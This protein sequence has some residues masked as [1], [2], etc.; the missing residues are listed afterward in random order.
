MSAQPG[1]SVVTLIKGRYEV[2]STLGSGGEAQ[3]VKALDRQHDRFVAL[4]I[5][6]VGDEATREELLS[7]ARV[8]FALPPHP[9][10]PIVR[11]DFFDGDTYVVAMDWVDGTSLAT[12][13]ADR[14]HPGLAPSSVLAYLAQAAE[15]LT[16]L[17][18]QSPPV[19]HGDVKPGNL[20]LARGGRIKLVDFGLSSAPNGSLP[21]AGTPG[22]RAP[23]LAAGGSL[24][25][26]SDVYA[27]ASTAFALLTGAAPTGVLPVWQH[28]SRAQAEQLEAAIRLGLATDPARRPKT[29]GELVERLQV[30]WTSGLPTG[31]VTF[32]VSD[33]EG[34]TAL[35]DARPE[36]MPDALVRHNELIAEAVEACGG[37]VIDSMGGGDST[38]SV[39]DS[40]PA[41]VQAALD[42]NRALQAEDWP[43][44]LRITARWGVHTG[45]AE[46][47]QLHYAGPTI[48]RAA[49][50]RAEAD[51]GQIFLSSATAELA[52]AHLPEGC[53]LVD[54]GPHRLKGIGSPERIHALSG[55]GVTAPL[56][57]TECPYRGLP[58]FEPDDRRFYFGRELVVADTIARLAPGQ[59][60]AVV[61][62][63][64]S[65]K[66]SLLRAGVVAAVRA[67]EVAAVERAHLLTP[68]GSGELGDGDPAAL[69]VVDQ[70][71]ETFTLCDDA[72]RRQAFIDALLAVDGPV[73]I[74]LRA[75]L[76]GQLGAYS[77]LARAV[78]NNQVLLGAMSDADLE[79]AVREP[80]RLAGL[81]LEPGLVE[82]VLRDVAGEPGALPLLSHAL[83]AT[84]E[85]R[86]GRTLTVEAYRR[87]GGVSAAI[88]HT[89]DG[90]VDALPAEQRQ[91][92]RGVFLR[93]TE[94]GE[95]TVETR[96]RV[97]IDELV[98]EGVSPDVLGALLEQLAE[99]RLL[100]LGD[101]TAEV[102]HEVLIREWPTL[103]GW[104]DEDREGIRL[105]RRVGQAARLWDAGGRE[106]SD[107]YGGTRL[108]AAREWAG[109]HRAG[110]NAGERA[111]IDASVERADDERRAER[112]ANRRLR[113]LLAG[114]AA[115]LAIAL[116]A[117]VVSLVQRD[118]ARAQSLTSDAERVGAQAV[119]EP[120]VDRS[121]LLAVAAVELQ[122][123]FQTRS[124]LLAVLQKRPALIRFFRPF[125]D[126]LVAVQESPDGRLL[127]VAD[128]ARKI[129]FIDTATWRRRGAY[130]RLGSSIA[131]RAMTFSPD[132]RTLMVVTVRASGSEL[133]RIDLASRGVRRF[134]NW[135]GSV[136]APPMGSAGVAYS[137]DGK[138]IA[139]SV[140]DEPAGNGIPTAERLALL[141]ASDGRSRWERRYPM[142]PGQE[143]PHV[144]FT[145][146]GALVTSA[147]HG[148]TILW[149]ART[150]RVLRRFAV[151]G[152]PALSADGRK[153]ALGMNSGFSSPAPASGSVAVLDLRT[154]RHRT[155][156]ANLPTA[157]IR[158]IAYTP[159]GSRIVAGAFDGVHVWDVA[160]GTIAESY[161]GQPGQRSVMTLD[162]RGATVIF[163]AQDGSIA[164][165]DIEGARRLG[166]AFRW[167]E[168]SLACGGF[169]DPCD[170]VNRESNLLAAA[171]SNGK[172]ALVDLRTLR[173]RR[174]LPARDGK[175]VGADVFLPDGRTLANGGAAGRV[176]LWDTSTG[177]AIRDMRFADPVL[178]TAA[179]PD[180]KL[181]AVQTKSARD[182]GSRVVVVRMATGER[183]QNHRVRGGAG[184]LEFSRD[185]RELVALGCC[186]PGASIVAWDTGSGR[187]LF[188]RRLV[189]HAGAIAVSPAGKLL[190]V[191]TEDGKVLLLDVRTG[192]QA[193]PPIRAAAGNI[194]M[195][196]FS[197][198]GRSFAVGAA[199]NA[200]SVWD[201]GARKRMGDPFGPYPGNI[202]Y[203][204]FEPNGRL[205]V[206][207]LEYAVEW[208][209]DVGTWQRFACR[210][211]GRDLTREEWNDL[212]PNR[213][214][215]SVCPPSS[216]GG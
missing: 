213:P 20:I 198:D 67:G 164:A 16:H 128:S 72:A 75:D 124:D 69:V 104:L 180:G 66:S 171:Q 146:A 154:G 24:S 3:I 191:G 201:L 43:P 166:R 55:P 17:H 77:E 131:P 44:G 54:L 93:L 109:T 22:Y 151:G 168:E 141:D 61:G 91:L 99:A 10:L 12:A 162:P 88:A 172:V 137:P 136:P 153:V 86:D 108:D 45:E 118:H 199:D 101:G 129:G 32:C 175:D 178:R 113:G 8:L 149:N 207:V 62:A 68:G 116:L 60:L 148:D 211:V 85:R 185:G 87:S 31:V 145:P 205:L 9:A 169:S 105:H 140:I 192:G 159:D 158:G 80:A 209:T 119:A 195:L 160:T 37:S 189:G 152:L 112:R 126:L 49:R 214:Y 63:S 7:E 27:L 4:K 123:R 177:R 57:A 187:P 190:G 98:P 92:L 135:R 2:L 102:A 127:A 50:L 176:T 161:V 13:L 197:P 65:G 70:F 34:S 30:G 14:G 21:R 42:A 132:G 96:R 130:V 173:V 121:L 33:V 52:A 51:G 142:R 15:A 100:T 155:L 179:S 138:R 78:A 1:P 184:G 18:S 64:G 182:P 202:P 19:I 89:A 139:V 58:A 196:S 47:H 183:V 56:A 90:V 167:A 35:W 210:A 103:R 208:P 143:E 181:L 84:W 11:E 122:D 6:P 120:N 117:G 97:R 26:A 83:R 25:R 74:G 163:G 38:V 28:I 36:A 188:T 170:V 133:D 134:R 29:P 73:V 41:A 23:E 79:R 39:F 76:Y 204:I 215:Q 82:L 206:D 157:W 81:R 212:L 186:R 5:R 114:T 216:R 53:S 46:R 174:T 193:Q 144:A 111:F 95:G 94:L 110:L 203:G 147:Q 59:L 200:V 107:L 125:S 150:G 194:L 165:Y 156:P 115:L 48:I 40:A 106:P 71:E